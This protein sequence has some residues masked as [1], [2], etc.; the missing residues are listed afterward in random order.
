MDLNELASFVRVVEL[1]TITAAAEA[2][3]VPKSTI[4]RRVARLEES[5]GVELLRRT[6]RALTVTDD[7]RMLH[8]R[9]Q[10][11]LAELAN[12]GDALY[13]ASGEARGTLVVAGPTELGRSAPVTGLFVEYRRRHPNVALDVRLEQ[14]VIDLAAEGIDIAIRPRALDQP[15]SNDLMTR[16]LAATEVGLFASREYLS[17]RGTPTSLDLREHDAVLHTVAASRPATLATRRGKTAQIQWGPA[18]VRCNDFDV[19]RALLEGGLGI[20]LLPRLSNADEP[21]NT[22]IRVLP[23]WSLASGRVSLVWPASRHLAPRV[24]AFIELAVEMLGDPSPTT[25]QPRK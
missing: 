2:E 18:V 13:E 11:A 22:L 24:R 10:S 8:A 20:G 21:A 23:K 17:R 4:S 16:T 1:G 19:V 9:S 5:L 14:R 25:R 3:G 12:V 15:R 6:A 7:G